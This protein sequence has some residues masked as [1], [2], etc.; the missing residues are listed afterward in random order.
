M[1]ARVAC[2]GAMPYFTNQRNCSPCR[3]ADARGVGAVDHV[4]AVRVR[5]ARFLLWMSAT[6]RSQVV[7]E[8]AVPV[9]FGKGV[10]RVAHGQLGP[11]LFGQPDALVIDQAGVFASFD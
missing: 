8:H 10:L 4:H 3:D 6:S 1:A 11:V 5:L 7:L 2:T 9:A